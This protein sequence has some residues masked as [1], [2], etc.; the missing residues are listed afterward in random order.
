MAN[1]RRRGTEFRRGSRNTRL[2][3][4]NR[5]KGTGGT[6]QSVLPSRSLCRLMWEQQQV[7]S[8]DKQPVKRFSQLVKSL[9]I[10]MERDP[11]L[12]PEGN[13]VE[14]RAATSQVD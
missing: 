9:V 12:H 3:V 4:Q 5:G 11:S 10:D 6:S 14:V 8:R 1:E 13:I 2:G 7:R